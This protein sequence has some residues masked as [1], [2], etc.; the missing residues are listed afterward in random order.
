MKISALMALAALAILSTSCATTP[1][2]QS[3]HNPD[4]G[5]V[6]IGSLDRKASQLLQ[7]AATLQQGNDTVLASAMKLSGHQTTD[8]T[9]G[10][11]D[12]SLMGLQYRIRGT[13][14]IVELR[15]LGFDH[16]VSVQDSGVFNPGGLITFTQYF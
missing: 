12:E 14:W 13:P 3:S 9:P 8:V 10:K 11:T 2:P 7:P 4:N 6:V 16:A 5:A 1:P 15:G